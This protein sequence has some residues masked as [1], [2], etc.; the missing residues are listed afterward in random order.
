MDDEN[1]TTKQLVAELLEMRQ[2][3]AELEKEKAERVRAEET[4]REL[5]VRLEDQVADRTAGLQAANDQLQSEITER[6][7][8]EKEIKMFKEALDSSSD[9]VGMSTAE[10]KHF[11]QN[12]A[13]D[14]MFGDIGDDP[15]LTV[16]VDEN[17]GREV[18]K[19]IMGGNEWNGEVA[20]YG[21]DEEVLDILLRA[22]SVKRDGRVVALVGV[23][24]D[25]SERKRTERAL[26]ESEE[27]FEQ[28]SKMDGLTGLLNRRGWNECLT[29]EEERARRYGHP[30]SVI[31]ADLDGLK[32]TN[33]AHGHKAGDDL[34]C[35]ATHCIQGA[36]R[37]VDKVARIGGDEFAVL[38][39]E[40][41][42]ENA[43]AILKRIEDALSAEGVRASWGMAMRNPSS[44][45]KGAMA[46]ADRLM[47][48]MKAKRR[49]GRST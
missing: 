14:K 27:R 32:E 40:C 34:I 47:Y 26:R 24:T 1:K 15:P 18:F 19:T 29:A 8:A 30:S 39:I 6:K 17:V 48:E 13:F 10:G 2:Q 42:E 25:I 28:L 35:R 4:L 5:N 16:Y 3:I 20:M 36:V 38:G 7:L 49:T 33:D 44:G 31:I 43:C 9:A 45:L 37:G 12:R 21:E 23:H 46:E 22:Y 41:S 11:Y